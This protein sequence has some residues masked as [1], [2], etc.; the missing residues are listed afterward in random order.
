VKRGLDI[1]FTQ[2][3][4]RELL[5][6][7][8]LAASASPFLQSKDNTPAWLAATQRILEQSL[9]RM[10]GGQLGHALEEG[11]VEAAEGTTLNV[12]GRQSLPETSAERAESTSGSAWKVRHSSVE[13][14]V[15]QG[16]EEAL[17]IVADIVASHA[18]ERLSKKG[19]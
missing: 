8:T 2:D 5:D 9:S 10:Y 4:V 7:F 16:T 15:R 14:E 11:T 12:E 3:A 1:L 18:Q 17:K 6:R 19:S 13:N